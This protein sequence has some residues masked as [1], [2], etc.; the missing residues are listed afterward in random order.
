MKVQAINTQTALRHGNAVKDAVR[1]INEH[2]MENSLTA[3]NVA[4]NC[5]YTYSYMIA[6]FKREKGVGLAEHIRYIRMKNAKRIIEEHPEYPVERICEECGYRNTTSLSNHFMEVHRM[7]VRKY[8]SSV[9]AG[10]KRT[11]HGIT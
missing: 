2:Y 10:Q 8:I 9:R 7:N 4:V 11:P 6:I 5:G 1:Y 3:M